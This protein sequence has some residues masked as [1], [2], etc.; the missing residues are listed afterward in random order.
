MSLVALLGMG[1]ASLLGEETGLTHLCGIQDLRLCMLGCSWEAW[2]G[3][4]L[5]PSKG[6]PCLCLSRTQEHVAGGLSSSLI[7]QQPNFSFCFMFPIFPQWP[8]DAE[9]PKHKDVGALTFGLL[10]VPEFA[11]SMLEKGPQAD[12]PEVRVALL[13]LSGV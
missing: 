9:P 3:E 11:T 7:S 8:I 13:V 1:R 5:W 12:L 2:S 6:S 10:F 4:N